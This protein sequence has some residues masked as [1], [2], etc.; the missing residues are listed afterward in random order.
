MTQVSLYSAWRHFLFVYPSMCILASIAIN[1]LLD[2]HHAPYFKWGVVGVCLLCMA[3][4]IMWMI[5]NHPYEYTYFNAMAGGFKKA[6]YEYE[7]DYWE[8]TAKKVVDHLMETESRMRGKDSI[9]VVTNM[10]S[11]VKG[12]IAKNYPGTRARVTNIGVLSRYGQ[13]WTYGVFNTIFLR[14]EFLEKNFP[15]CNTVFA[16]NI[17]GMPVTTLVKD[18][19]REDWQ[20]QEAFTRGEYNVTDSLLRHYLTYVCPANKGLLG[21]LALTQGNMNK[22][23]EGIALAEQCLAMNISPYANYDALC[24]LGVAYGNLQKFDS[25]IEKLQIA[26]KIFPAYT[27]APQILEQVLIYKQKVERGE[28]PRFT[29]EQLMQRNQQQSAPGAPAPPPANK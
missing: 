8:I 1:D 13:K 22:C 17:D 15:L 26:R 4:P 6:Y 21:L 28:I 2:F 29:E 5:K 18:T 20:A 3:K 25:A 16:E 11:F 7:T 9:Y 14:P 23:R 27:S 19:I 10:E 12:Y 24:G